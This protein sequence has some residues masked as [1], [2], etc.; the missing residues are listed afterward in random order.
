M[1]G[2]FDIPVRV[3]QVRGGDR[4]ELCATAE[5]CQ[6]IARRLG[7]PAIGRLEANATLERTGETVRA[8]GRLRA[9]LTQECVVTG[10]PLPAHVDAPFDII[11]TPES[12][13]AAPEP[14]IEL[15]AEDC[16]TMFYDGAA[17]PLGDAIADTLALSIEPYPR[18]AG[19]DAV[20]RESGILSEGEAGPFAALAALKGKPDSGT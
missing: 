5:Q 3:D 14:E 17:I 18:S 13:A 11:F 20:L 2:D 4:V 12:P 19:A 10:E 6:A 7:L 9:A 1:T 16:D 8:T 15:G